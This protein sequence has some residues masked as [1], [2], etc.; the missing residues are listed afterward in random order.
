MQLGR[1]QLR[2]AQESAVIKTAYIEQRLEDNDAADKVIPPGKVI[3]EHAAA[4]HRAQVG[5][6]VD[7]ALAELVDRDSIVDRL[8]Q[9]SKDK[10]KVSAD[11][12]AKVFEDNR[13]LPWGQAV[14]KT[15]DG[16]F[17]SD[18]LTDRAEELWRD[19]GIGGAAPAE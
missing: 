16:R 19:Q 17:E 18:E 8:V 15:I 6:A 13:A 1:L 10:A 4:L 14:A 7:E 9:E 11:E 2:P 12:V 5:D 3:D